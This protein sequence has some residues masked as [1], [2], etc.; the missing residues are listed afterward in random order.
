MTD[1]VGQIALQWLQFGFTSTR[2][3]A[4]LQLANHHAALLHTTWQAAKLPV[5][6][7]GL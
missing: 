7:E 5:A 2:P 3:D 4:K 6:A 1:S